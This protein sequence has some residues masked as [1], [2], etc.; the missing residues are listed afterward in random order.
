[1]AP[2][3]QNPD[4]EQPAP[5]EPAWRE[6]PPPPPIPALLREPTRPKAASTPAA[7]ESKESLVGMGRAWAVAL[8]FVFTVLAGAGLGWVAGRFAGHQP[9]W[10]MGGLAL[11]FAVALIR[12]LRGT[13]REERAE[14]ER[15]RLGK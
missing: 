10:V 9:A 15:K 14:A 13:M 12:I 7:S 11:G 4:G 5:E 1:M 3:H 6:P 8:D 2:E